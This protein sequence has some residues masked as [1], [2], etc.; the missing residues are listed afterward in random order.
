MFIS[1][2]LLERQEQEEGREEEEV[3]ITKRLLERQGQL[4]FACTGI[5]LFTY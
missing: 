3:F 4:A 2:R 5:L 1:K